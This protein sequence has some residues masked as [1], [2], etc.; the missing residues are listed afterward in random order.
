MPILNN[1]KFVFDIIIK[2]LKK[3]SIFLIS[4]FKKIIN[5]HNMQMKLGKMCTISLTLT[6]Y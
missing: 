5:M 6:K 3:N 4:I 2:K 1:T